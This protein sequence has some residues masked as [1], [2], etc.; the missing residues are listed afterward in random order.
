M[1]KVII[2]DDREFVQGLLRNIFCAFRK[3]NSLIHKMKSRFRKIL[4]ERVLN[5]NRHTERQI[6][7]NAEE[8]AV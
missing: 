3:Q 1:Q 8:L 7:L 6:T 2:S 4:S 5:K